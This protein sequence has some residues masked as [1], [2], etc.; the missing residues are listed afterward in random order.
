MLA[1][2]C[3]TPHVVAD[4]VVAIDK[5]IAKLRVAP[6]QVP[7]VIGESIVTNA[8][9]VDRTRRIVVIALV[10]D[11]VV[12]GRA[13]DACTDL[14]IRDVELREQVQAVGNQALVEISIAVI[15]VRVCHQLVVPVLDA[16]GVGVFDVGIETHFQVGI[17]GIELQR[18][19]AGQH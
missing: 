5:R 2:P 10:V 12:P 3:H 13:A 6:V 16:P 9:G 1:Q 14:F 7:G 18:L 15:Q 17:V 11:V 4:I 8:V 19:R